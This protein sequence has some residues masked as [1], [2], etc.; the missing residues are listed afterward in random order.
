[1]DDVVRNTDEAQGH[2]LALAELLRDMGMQDL[3]GRLAELY[4]EFRQTETFR[5][6]F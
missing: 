2:F 6:S 1:M 3:L 5:Q 4:L